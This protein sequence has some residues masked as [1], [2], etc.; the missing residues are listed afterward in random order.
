MVSDNSMFLGEYEG[1]NDSLTITVFTEGGSVL[2]DVDEDVRNGCPKAL[3][4]GKELDVLSGNINVKTYG[5]GGE[6][7]ESKDSINIKGGYIILETYDDGINVEKILNISNGNLYCCSENNDGIDSNGSIVIR[8]G[9]VVSISKHEKD[10]SFDVEQNRLCFYGGTAIGIGRDVVDVMSAYIPYYTYPKYVGDWIQ[11]PS[12]DIN[13]H[14]DSYMSIADGEQVMYAV[15]IP[16]DMDKVYITVASSNFIA[17]KTYSVAE[18]HSIENESGKLFEGRLLF[19]GTSTNT[20]PL[21]PFIPIYF[22]PIN[23][24][25]LIL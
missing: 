14:K 6:G 15:R 23:I 12:E 21:F 1:V 9:C 7:F 20:K 10:E 22:A 18:S 16:N 3:K 24:G 2:N 17:D 5:M 8:G 4:S 13:L 11:R 19:G 25:R